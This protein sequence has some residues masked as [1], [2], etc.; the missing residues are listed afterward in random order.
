MIDVNK[1]RLM[2]RISMYENGQ[3]KKDL[4]MNRSKQSTYIRMKMIESILCVT[5]AYLI[6]AGLYSTRYVT[7][8]VTEGLGSFKKIA[9][10]LLAVYL[11]LLILSLIMTY[12]YCRNKYRKAYHRIVQYDRHLARLEKYISRNTE[13][14]KIP[15]GKKE[16][17]DI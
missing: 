9:A 11:V 3:G 2:T 10:V 6:V 16:E 13:E 4:K 17:E 15:E 1:V 5:V 14:T 7:M 12:F 8:I